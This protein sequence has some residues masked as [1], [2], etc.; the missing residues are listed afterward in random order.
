MKGADDDRLLAEQTAYYRATALSYGQYETSGAGPHELFAAFD[1]FSPSGHVLELACGPGIWTERILRTAASVTAVDASPE[2]LARAKARVGAER[3]MFV[4]A[5]LFAWVPD[6]RFDAVF[7]GFWLSHVPPE[8][9]DS[10]WKLVER[11]LLPA[12]RVLFVDDAYREVDELTEG[13]A[14]WTIRRRAGDGATYRL[15]KVPYRPI[16]L[17]AR[18]KALGWD[19]EVRSAGGLFYCGAGARRATRALDVG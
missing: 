3:V 2:M 8:R 9:F 1:R 12:G 15:V 7:F 4:E 6:R 14:S 19:I 5:D 13:Q 18:L 17:E 11:C 16:E 10:F